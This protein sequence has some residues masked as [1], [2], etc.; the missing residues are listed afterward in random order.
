[1]AKIVCPTAPLSD[2]KQSARDACTFMAGALPADTLGISAAVQQAIPI[3]HIIVLMKENRS[4]DHLFGQLSMQGQPDAE[5]APASFSNPDTNGLAVAR[6]HE[7]GVTGAAVR[8]CDPYDPSHQ[9]ADMHAMVDNGAMDGF[10]KN[11]AATATVGETSTSANSDGHFVMGYYDQTDIPFYYWLA[12]NFALADHDFASVRSGTWADRD[13]L[14]AGTSRGIMDTQS[15]LGALPAGTKLIFDQLDTAKVSWQV[16]TDDLAPL[17]FSVDWTGR[18]MWGSTKLFFSKLANGTLESVTFIDATTDLKTPETD[19]HPPADV[20]T[21]E[22]W[23][24]MLVQN[25]LTSPLWKDTALIF[26]YDEAGGFADHVPPGN[27]CA[28]S[29]DQ[30]MFTE[31]GVRVP[32]IVISPYARP[33]FVSHK[34]HQHTSITRFI[35][36][37]FNLPA[38]TA[39]DANSDALLDLFDFNCPALLTPPSGMPAAGT[40][41]CMSPP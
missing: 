38:L 21:G 29:S 30:S 34:V 22:A 7:V 33:K 24:R 20:Q 12:S 40:G 1:M 2:P 9:W 14:V 41:G 13:Y 6:Y 19:E 26:T 15:A 37:V 4:F 10:V 32:L 31:L 8:T 18:K 39:R 25:V 16:Y 28:P 17:E 23:T 5:P 35:E 27:S 3:K 36:T 11:A